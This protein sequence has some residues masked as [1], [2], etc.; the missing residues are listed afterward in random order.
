MSH[1][2]ACAL[3]YASNHGDCDHWLQKYGKSMKWF[4][5]EVTKAVNSN[6]DAEIYYC[7]QV[8]AFKDRENAEAMLAKLKKSGYNGYITTK[9]V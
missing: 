7:V 1:K 6:T 9:G 4:R 8:G 3:G 5:D 2:E